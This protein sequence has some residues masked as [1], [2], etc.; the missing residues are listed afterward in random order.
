MEKYYSVE[1]NVQILVGL[2]HVHNI[3]KVVVSPGTTN[4]CLVGSLQQDPFFEIYS[5]VDE[6][7]AAYMACGLAAESGEPVVLSCTGAT[8]SRNYVPGLTEAFYRHLP[9][10]AVTATQYEGRIGHAREQVLDRSVQFRDLVRCS[11]HLENVQEPEEEWAMTVRANE[12]L[13]TL[14]DRVPG[15]AHINLTTRYSKDFSVKELPPVRGIFRHYVEDSLPV[16]PEGKILIYVGAHL[17]WSEELTREA[18][19]FC[20][21][22]NACIVGDLTAGYRGKYFIPYHLSISQTQMDSCMAGARLLIHLGDVAACS[23]GCRAQESWRVHPDGRVC[24]TFG[25]LRHV[26]AMREIDFFR[27]MNRMGEGHMRGTA[28]YEACLAERED[29]VAQIPETPFAAY[30]I[31][32]ETMPRLPEGC[33]LH[34]GIL[35]SLRNFQYVDVPQGVTAFANTGGFGID[36]NVSA[37][38]GASLASPSKLYF[39][40]VGDL[41][42]FYDMNALG[43]RHVSKNIRL[44]LV[45][46]GVGTEFKNYNHP[47][48]RFGEAGDAFMAARGHYGRQSRDLVRHYAE[49]LGFT[50]LSADSKESFLEHIDE[51]TSPKMAERP[52]LFEVFTDSEAESE[53]L[54]LVQSAVSNL[55]GRA[56][57]AI[58]ENLGEKNVDRLKR[59]LRRS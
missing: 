37:L 21:L 25:V 55:K 49:D 5:S 58:K 6:R 32:R 4:V 16:V 12:A 20:E 42:F 53:S 31:A 41:A 10:L 46:N 9:V 26:F 35:N 2:L 18:E 30:F 28:F 50:Y 8:A 7:S 14:K 45:N 57:S 11:V 17:P 36:G 29:I 40:V 43:N 48:A 1:R 56:K 59:F 23:A 51:F 52:I 54:R 3:K 44:M 19:R 47:A 24:D 39:G 22:Y 38:L 27:L 13:L 15:P 34:L 33:A